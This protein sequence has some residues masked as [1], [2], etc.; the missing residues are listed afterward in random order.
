MSRLHRRGLVALA[1]DSLLVDLFDGHLVVH[2]ASRTR[3]TRVCL[4]APL[5]SI[6]RRGLGHSSR[7]ADLLDEDLVVRLAYILGRDLVVRP[8]EQ[9]CSSGT[10]ALNGPERGLRASPRV[11]LSLINCYMIKKDSSP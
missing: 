8:A 11:C 6:A 9:T 2:P 4:F 10:C 1:W 7:L 3:S 5:R